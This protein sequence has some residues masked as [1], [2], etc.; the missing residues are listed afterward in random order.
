[1]K[2]SV[3]Q[4]TGNTHVI[5]DT[6]NTLE[7]DQYGAIFKS[8]ITPIPNNPLSTHTFYKNLL[9]DD[10]TPEEAER[11]RDLLRRG[12]ETGLWENEANYALVRFG[13]PTCWRYFPIPLL[14]EHNDLIRSKSRAAKRPPHSDGWYRHK[15]NL[16]L[17]LIGIPMMP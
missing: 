13:T 17:K 11:L 12:V 1:M 15:R 6:G 7:H 10:V 2:I 8:V 5:F 16:V 9:S 4:N 3:N 14:F